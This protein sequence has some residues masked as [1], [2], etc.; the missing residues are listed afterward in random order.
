MAEIQQ[1][2]IE[3][4]T[5]T[6]SSGKNTET[7]RWPKPTMLSASVG[8]IVPALIKAQSAFTPV[9]KSKEARIS[10]TQTYTYASL[11]DCFDM[12]LPI[13]NKN[14]IVLTQL[15]WPD[16]KGATKLWS[17]LLHSSGEWI[18]SQHPINPEG[19]NMFHAIASAIT[20]AR[21]YTF[22]PQA[23][24]STEEDDDCSAAIQA[25]PKQVARPKPD[26]RYKEQ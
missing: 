25:V 2:K 10:Q 7:Y 14:G 18:A 22:C 17:L 15:L 24:I 12:A 13:L 23:G 16:E 6:N 3:K 21:R 8:K 9:P 5:T 11:D 19:R 4:N 26:R 1:A 20:Y